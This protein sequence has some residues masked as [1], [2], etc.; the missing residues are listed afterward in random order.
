MTSLLIEYDRLLCCVFTH[1]L[2]TS[3]VTT[4]AVSL[5][6]QCELSGL[7]TQQSVTLHTISRVT[8]REGGGEVHTCDGDARNE[9]H[10][11]RKKKKDTK[12]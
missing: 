12:I 3:Q 10:V 1:I 2:N 4:D 5:F 9:K 6:V 7:F 11:R 8:T